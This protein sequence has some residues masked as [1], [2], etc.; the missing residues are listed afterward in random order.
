VLR[1]EGRLAGAIAKQDQVLTQNPNAQGI[2]RAK[3]FATPAAEIC[4]DLN[5]QPIAPKDLA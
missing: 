2:S 5:R 3:K 4:G 1:D